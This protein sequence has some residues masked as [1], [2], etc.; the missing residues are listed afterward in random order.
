[1]HEAE[2]DTESTVR[3]TNKWYTAVILG[4]APIVLYAF[5]SFMYLVITFSGIRSGSLMF[6][7]VQGSMALLALVCLGLSVYVWMALLRNKTCYAPKL[8]HLLIA[9]VRIL[10]GT[11]IMMYVPIYIVFAGMLFLSVLQ[12]GSFDS[13]MRF[14][15]LAMSAVISGAFA[16]GF[17]A[18]GWFLLKGLRNARERMLGVSASA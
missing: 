2:S 13:E 14:V 4:A 17:A 9:H 6:V 7:G 10:F 3:I 8:R 5:L 16:F 15:Y 1:M 18:A 12:E 11:I